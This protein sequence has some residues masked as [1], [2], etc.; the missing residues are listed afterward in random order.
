ME[1]VIDHF[2][3]FLALVGQMNAV[4]LF[5]YRL[6]SGITGIV[7]DAELRSS[8]SERSPS[9]DDLPGPTTCWGGDMSQPQ[10]CGKTDILACELPKHKVEWTLAVGA[11]TVR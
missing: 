4:H 10:G 7:T 8:F 9:I 3:E 6:A 2:T 1:P 5:R 11:Y